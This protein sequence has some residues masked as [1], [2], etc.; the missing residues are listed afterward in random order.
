[1]KAPWILVWALVAV[2]VF[3]QG[4]VPNSDRGAAFD[5]I[6]AYVDPTTA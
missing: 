3:A 4:Q 6:L 1:M 5:V 2:P